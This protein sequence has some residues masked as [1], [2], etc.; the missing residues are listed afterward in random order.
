MDNTDNN[1]QAAGVISAVETILR[2]IENLSPSES[3]RQGL[4][5]TPQRVYKALSELYGGYQVDIGELLTQATFGGEDDPIL[6]SHS[7]LVLVRNIPFYSNCEHHMVPF[8]GTADVGYI[9]NGRVVGLSKLPRLVDALARRLQV[10]ERLTDDITHYLDQHLEPKGAMAVIRAE[11]LCMC[12]R[13]IKKPGS[14]TITSS[15]TGVFR[16]NPSAK[17]EFLHLIGLPR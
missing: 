2:H 17:E 11:H 16:T 12:S 5:K 3:L 7:Q 9:P 13:G 14:F 4:E 6:G 10:Q 15:I 1:Q 8:F